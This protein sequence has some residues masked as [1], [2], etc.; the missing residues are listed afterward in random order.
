MKKLMLFA[1]S[2]AGAAWLVASFPLVTLFLLLATSVWL[3]LTGQAFQWLTPSARHAP[4]VALVSSSRPLR[5]SSSLST[6][7]KTPRGHSSWERR[8]Q[9]A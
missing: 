1:A 2:A 3:Y 8:T 5:R 9:H 4:W 6:T 7:K